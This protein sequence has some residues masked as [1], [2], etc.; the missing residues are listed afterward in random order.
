MHKLLST[1]IAFAFTATSGLAIAQDKK[2][3]KKMAEKP[4]ATKK[5][6][7]PAAA[8]K[9]DKSAEAPKKKKKEGC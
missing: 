5:A 2:D 1:L 4:A 6:E 3:E 7:K 9:A 8:K